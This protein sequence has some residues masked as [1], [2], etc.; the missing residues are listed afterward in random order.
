MHLFI[1]QY[2]ARF[3]PPDVVVG[4]ENL[5]PDPETGFSGF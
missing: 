2:G 1:P 5:V 4:P 3:V